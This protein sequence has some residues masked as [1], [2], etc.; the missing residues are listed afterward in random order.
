[1]EREL[2][3]GGFARLA[4]LLQQAGA[5]NVSHTLGTIVTYLLLDKDVLNPLAKELEEVYAEQD[6]VVR[7]PTWKELEKLP[8]LNACVQ[9]GLRMSI[10]ALN[11][12]PRIFPEDD[13]VVCGK[14]I[15]RNVCASP[16]KIFLWPPEKKEELEN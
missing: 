13:M 2:G 10:G 3:N 15:P 1:M 11:R 16:P 5:M 4:Q 12:S 6:G 14:T 9:E 7:A 8:Y